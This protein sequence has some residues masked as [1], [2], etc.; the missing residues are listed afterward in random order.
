MVLIGVCVAL[1]VLLLGAGLGLDVGRMALTK[2]ALQT[3]YD[4]A[5]LA[6][7]LELDGSA[8]GQEKARGTVDSWKD[9]GAFEQEAIE[10]ATVE[11]GRDEKGVEFVRVSGGVKMPL[12]L[13]KMAVRQDVSVVWA[14]ALARRGDAT[15]AK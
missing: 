15:A 10:G 9:G 6:A 14:R 2:K 5:A 11:F 13:V 7:S 4:G 12:T 1:F 3:V 8:K